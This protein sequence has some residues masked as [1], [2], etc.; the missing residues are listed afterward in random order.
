[1]FNAS[2]IMTTPV[3]SINPSNT[4]KE[5]VQILAEKKISGLPVVDFENK[6]IGMISE[7]DIVEYTNKLHVIRLIN[8]SVW[9]SPYDDVSFI[10]SYKKGF[11]LLSKTKV[12][13]VMSKKVVSVKENASG[14]EIAKLMKKKNVNRIPVTNDDG[15]L[16]GI[17]S[18]ADLIN[19]LASQ[20]TFSSY[21]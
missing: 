12:E 10:T 13:E 15:V 8:S 20:E 19:Y 14:E 1:M 6:M 16:I 18:R 7:K 3:I 2:D 5:A 17:I 9:I 21:S 11:E 4:L